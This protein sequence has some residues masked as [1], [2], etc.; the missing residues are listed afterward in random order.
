MK[1]KSG[2][3]KS[4]MRRIKSENIKKERKNVH[5]MPAT[6]CLCA[7]PNR[8]SRTMTLEISYI[9]KQ[10]ARTGDQIR[11]FETLRLLRFDIRTPLCSHSLVSFSSLC[12]TVFLPTWY[13]GFGVFIISAHGLKNYPHPG[14]PP[15]LRKGTRAGS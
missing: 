14:N 11:P 4:S 13:P 7:H 1:R 12:P 9:S 2:S 10:K 5:G 15:R 8:P 3:H 6:M